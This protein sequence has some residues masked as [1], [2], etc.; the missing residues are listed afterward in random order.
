[1]SWIKAAMDLKF[2]SRKVSKA[3]GQNLCFV[4]VLNLAGF[5]AELLP[6]DLSYFKPIKTYLSEKNR[7]NSEMY[8]LGRSRGTP[9][10]SRLKEQDWETPP[11]LKQIG[12][13]GHTGGKSW[14]SDL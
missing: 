13:K 8:G 1:M 11:R 7:P 9:H 2:K 6:G 10:N 12:I 5:S 3:R 4:I 14:A